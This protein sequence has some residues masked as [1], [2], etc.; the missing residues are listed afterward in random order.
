MILKNTLNGLVPVSYHPV[1]YTED[2]A[3]SEHTERRSDLPVK[4]LV[5]SNITNISNITSLFLK[6]NQAKGS[7]K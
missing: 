1:L 6:L 4:T 2:P 5:V 7:R 3:Q